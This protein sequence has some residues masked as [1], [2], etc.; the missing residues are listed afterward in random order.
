VNTAKA[1]GFLGLTMPQV[2][3]VARESEHLA[4]ADVVQLLDSVWHEERMAALLI[5]GRKFSRGDQSLRR[6]IFQ[7]YLRNR[8]PST[9][10]TS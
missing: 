3:S 9:T 2:R 7:L 4:I 10:G 8:A 1:I 6:R 5:L